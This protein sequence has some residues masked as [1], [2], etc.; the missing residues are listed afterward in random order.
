MKIINS[1]EQIEST[2]SAT[3][4]YKQCLFL[5]VMKKHN[6]SMTSFRNSGALSSSLLPPLNL[7][8]DKKIDHIQCD[9]IISLIRNLSPNNA[10]GSDGI[11][12]QMLL[13]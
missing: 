8:T 13:L 4:S 1:D 12:G 2:R 3:S 7:L 10:S 5:L 6:F 11:S 9:E